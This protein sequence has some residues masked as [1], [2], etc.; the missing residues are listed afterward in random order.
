[1][2]GI[3]LPPTCSKKPAGDAGCVCVQ[4]MCIFIGCKIATLVCV[5][6]CKKE[7]D[8]LRRG[9]SAGDEGFPPPSKPVGVCVCVGWGAKNRH[10]VG[11]I[12][13]K[14]SALRARGG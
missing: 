9:D 5:G 2:G 1:M 10:L 6:W 3:F 8:F 11:A 4:K 7:R 14:S 12:Q 13:K